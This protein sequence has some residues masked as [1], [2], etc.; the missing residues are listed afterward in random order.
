MSLSKA[1]D[2]HGI[3]RG[4]LTKNRNGSCDRDVAFRIATIET[5]EDEDGDPVFIAY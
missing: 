4:R 5:G 2:Q 1:K 3:V